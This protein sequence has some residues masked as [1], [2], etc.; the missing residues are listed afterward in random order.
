MFQVESK[1][2]NHNKKYLDYKKLFDIFIKS[3][4]TG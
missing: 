3:D 4:L 2:F 1:K